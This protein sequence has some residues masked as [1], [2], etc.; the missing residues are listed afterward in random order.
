MLTAHLRDDEATDTFAMSKGNSTKADVRALWQAAADAARQ[1]DTPLAMEK[2]RS[3]RVL[4]PR[5]LEIL[6]FLADLLH[7]SG[8]MEEARSLLEEGKTIA[9]DAPVLAFKLGQLYRAFERFDRARREFRIVL[10][11]QPEH[12]PSREALVLVEVAEG[13]YSAAEKI[14]DGANGVAEQSELLELISIEATARGADEVAQRCGERAFELLPNAGTALSLARAQFHAGAD[15]AAKAQLNWILE[16]AD[17]DATIRARAIG[18]LADIADRDGDFEA[19]FE[20]YA[21]SK[22]LLREAY[23][24]SNMN[25]AGSFQSLVERLTLSVGRLSPPMQEESAGAPSPAKHVFLLGFPR[26]G[27]TLLEQCLSGNRAVVTSDETDALRQAIQPFLNHPDPFKAFEARKQF[28]YQDIRAA[29]WRRIV[30]RRPSLEDKVFIDKMPLNSVFAGFIPTL[31]PEAKVIFAVRDPRDVVISCF[32]RRFGMN[33]ATYEFCTLEGAVSLYCAVMH[34]FSLSQRNT[35]LAPLL[36]RYED[37]VGD[38][39]G[40]VSK[41][42]EFIGIDW[43]EEMARFSERA[44]RR[45]LSTVSAPQLTQ[46]LYD[47][48]GSWRSYG[49]FLAPHL[50]KLAPWISHFGYKPA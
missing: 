46:D 42:C 35:R 12:H 36:C 49:P 2:L 9:P 3:A 8:R 11:Q 27:T 4:A 7:F 18:T 37:V 32:R 15:R 31:F 14:A 23:E 30:Q 19:A 26:T 21:S 13:D 41:L 17:T 16:E 29:Y 48:S 45:P 40:T 50:H 28:G 47:G 6:L 33:S 24:R 38:L 34:L 43:Q 10:A 25:R 20:Q 5:N 44:N 39:R 22:R 1:G